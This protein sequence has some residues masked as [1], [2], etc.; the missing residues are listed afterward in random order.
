MNRSISSKAGGMPIRSNDNRLISFSRF[1]LGEGF[2][3][4]DSILANVKLSISFLGQFEF[5]GLGK[6][7]LFT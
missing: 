4:T 6:F 2:I 7:G 5:L 1:A 3:F